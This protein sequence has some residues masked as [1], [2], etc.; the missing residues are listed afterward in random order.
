MTYWIILAYNLA[1]NDSRCEVL[2]VYLY[3]TTTAPQRTICP[4]YIKLPGSYFTLS[5]E[6]APRPGSAE[7]TEGQLAILD[8]LTTII[9]GTFITAHAYWPVSRSHSCLHEDTKL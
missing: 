4:A 5:L 6:W 7:R 3:M 1:K 9:I 2:Y 8:C